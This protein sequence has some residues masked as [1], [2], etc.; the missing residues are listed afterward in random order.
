MPATIAGEETQIRHFHSVGK[1]SH[2]GLQPHL[3]D[4]ATARNEHGARGVSPADRC[5]QAPHWSIFTH[6]VY[7]VWPF[8]RIAMELVEAPPA[9]EQSSRSYRHRLPVRLMHWLNLVCVVVLLM[10]GLQI[11]NAHPHLYWAEDSDSRRP[12]LSIGAIQYESGPV[13]VTWVAGHPFVTDGVLGASRS[14]PDGRTVQRAFPSWATVPGPR[15]LAMGRRWHF[16]FAWIFVINGVAYLTYS[17]ASGHLRRDLTPT[18][19]EARHIGGS[20]KDHL[21]FRHPTGEA[22]T[23]YNVLQKLAYLAVILV[24][25]PLLVLAGL[26]MSPMLDSV[27]PGWV[28][29]MGGRQAARSL[30][31]VAAAGLV[32]FFAVH[33]FEVLVSGPWNQV[34]SMITGYYNVPPDKRDAP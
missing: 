19:G 30:H 21:L 10:S 3:P 15:W 4:I 13:G 25:L 2:L 12:W 6:W 23:R 22:A 32:L 24:L 28:G 33:I 34:R 26:A 1:E 29:W 17:L 7:V 8:E 5:P 27:I 16:F 11:F 9:P 18:R 31:F 20:I 14:A